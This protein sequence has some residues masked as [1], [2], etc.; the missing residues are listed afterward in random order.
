[1]VEL[2]AGVALVSG[3]VSVFGFGDDV[4][5]LGFGPGD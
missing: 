3:E 4:E 1:V 5:V 2:G